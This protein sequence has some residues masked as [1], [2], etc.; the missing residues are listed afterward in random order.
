MCGPRPP[1]HLDTLSVAMG[2]LASMLCGHEEIMPRP[3]TLEVDVF[4]GFEEVLGA[5]HPFT[6]LAP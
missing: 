4:R 2:N 6:L 1:S 5:D 3:R